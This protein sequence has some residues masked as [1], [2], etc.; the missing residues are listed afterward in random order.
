MNSKEEDISIAH[1]LPSNS[2]RKP[3]LAKFVRRVT[4]LDFTKNKRKL[5]QLE[6]YKNV[7]VF[8]DLSKARVNFINLMKADDRINSV[9]SREGTLFYEWKNENLA[10]KN[11]GLYEGGNDLNYSIEG[12]LNCCNSFFHHHAQILI[13]K[14]FVSQ[15]F[16]T[17]TRK[18]NIIQRYPQVVQTSVFLTKV[19]EK[20]LFFVPNTE[21]SIHKSNKKTMNILKVNVRSLRKNCKT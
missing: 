10:Y 1:R 17:T 4:K 18:P 15:L 5:A 3:I 12:V 2:E 8:E 20:D 7:K 13:I 21:G 6:T 9:W 14:L 16:H 11:H 19:L